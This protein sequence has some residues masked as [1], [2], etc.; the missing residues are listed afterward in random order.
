[1]IAVVEPMRIMLRVMKQYKELDCSGLYTA[2]DDDVIAYNQSWSAER[3]ELLTEQSLDGFMNAIEWLLKFEKI[4]AINCRDGSSYE[5]KNIAEPQVGYVMNGVFI[6]AAIAAGFRIKRDCGWGS[7]SAC[8]NISTRAFRKYERKPS[9]VWLSEPQIDPC[10]ARDRKAFI[11]NGW[12]RQAYDLGWTDDDLFG[13]PNGVVWR[14]RDRLVLAISAQ[15]V[16]VSTENGAELLP[17]YRVP[18]WAMVKGSMPVVSAAV[19][20]INAA[21]AKPARLI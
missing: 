19:I 11:V 16:A 15:A 2:D 3:G 10:F 5:L 8:F 4:R 13:C 17:R 9:P 20:G 18:V 14:I 12:R 21:V 7:R 6:A 1:M